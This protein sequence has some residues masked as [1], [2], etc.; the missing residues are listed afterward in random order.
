MFRRWRGGL[1]FCVLVILLATLISSAAVRAQK[2]E[3]LYFIDAHSQIDNR[4]DPAIVIQLMNDGNVRHIILSTTGRA[5]QE[6]CST[7]RDSFRVRS[8]LRCA[9][10]T[11]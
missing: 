8:C 7:W 6:A 5:S 3:G 11:T 2:P 1:R 9:R 4:T 10:S